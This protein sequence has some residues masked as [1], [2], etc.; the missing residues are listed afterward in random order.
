MK[1][2]PLTDLELDKVIKNNREFVKPDHRA[3]KH[4]ILNERYKFMEPTR[5]KNILI[6]M[7]SAAWCDGSM[8]KR[9]DEV[10]EKMKN[11]H[12]W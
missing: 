1:G 12:K 2:T 6:L 4:Y 5:M 3:Y 7:K 9:I 8:H 11:K 10:L